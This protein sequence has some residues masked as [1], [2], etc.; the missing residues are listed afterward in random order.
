[1]LW[2]TKDDKLHKHFINTVVTFW[3][4]EVRQGKGDLLELEAYVY[5]E[6][7]SVNPLWAAICPNLSEALWMNV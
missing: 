7:C 6:I 5:Q 3:L 1:M 2:I 4:Q